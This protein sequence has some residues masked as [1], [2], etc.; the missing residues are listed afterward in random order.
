MA[1]HADEHDYYI[2]PYVVHYGSKTEVVSSAPSEARNNVF[3]KTTTLNAKK[4]NKTIFGGVLRAALSGIL[5]K[6]T[7]LVRASPSTS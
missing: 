4:K 2:D 1:S 7:E 5:R 3:N 6:D